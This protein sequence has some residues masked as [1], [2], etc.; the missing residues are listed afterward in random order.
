[1]RKFFQSF[2]F[3]AG[4]DELGRKYSVVWL[5]LAQYDT[6]TGTWNYFG[7]SS[8]VNRYIGWNYVVEWYDKDGNVIYNDS[9]RINL[10]N[11]SCHENVFPYFMGGVVK[12]VSVNGTLLETA[13]N[14]VS[15]TTS[16]FIK[17]SDEITVNEDNS[18]SINAISASKLVQGED[19]ELVL[20]GGGAAL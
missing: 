6:A 5:A 10:S 15:I 14:T 3:L 19:E 11:E 13:N 16:D 2:S 20:N 12:N 9:I 4:I 1:M 17:S 8:S 7:K 18:L